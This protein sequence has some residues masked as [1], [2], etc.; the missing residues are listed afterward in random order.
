[1]TWRC[2]RD[3]TFSR[4]GIVRA[5]GRQTDGKTD[6]HT[7]TA[8]TRASIACNLVYSSS[9]RIPGYPFLALISQYSKYTNRRQRRLV[10]STQN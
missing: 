9:T 2:L 1:M 8:N 7:M 4:F 5:C 10:Y 3:P 6:R